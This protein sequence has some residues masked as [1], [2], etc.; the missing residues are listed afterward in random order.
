[1]EEDL[2]RRIREKPREVP[3]AKSRVCFSVDRAFNGVKFHRRGK[4]ALGDYV[5]SSVSGKGNQG[6]VLESE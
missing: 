1:M 2:V 6:R 5:E 4:E 3:E